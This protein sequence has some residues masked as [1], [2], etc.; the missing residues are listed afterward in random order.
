MTRP[1]VDLPQPDS[2]TRPSVSPRAIVS[3][4]SLTACTA[5]LST[6]PPSRAAM[7]SPSVRCGA[8]R[9]ETPSTVEEG[10]AHAAS[11]GVRTSG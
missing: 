3:E 6:A 7:R 8:K 10:V 1:S 2:P 4:T 5:R 9:F 11:A